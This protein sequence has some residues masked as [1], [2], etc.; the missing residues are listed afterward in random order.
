MGYTL[1]LE[2]SM[3]K[4]PLVVGDGRYEILHKL[5][6]MRSIKL[7]LRVHKDSEKN[8]QPPFAGRP[9]GILPVNWDYQ[10]L[11]AGSDPE[12]IGPPPPVGRNGPF[13]RTRF[14]ARQRGAR[15]DSGPKP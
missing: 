6:E 5:W 14:G 8:A 10:H 13:R 7:N 9:G 1:Y 2:N 4:L 11:E 3:A 12:G 15:V